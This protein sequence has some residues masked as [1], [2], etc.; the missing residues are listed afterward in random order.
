MRARPNTEPAA[1]LDSPTSILCLQ[2]LP[3][4]LLTPDDDAGPTAGTP[5]RATL[6]IRRSS[7][8]TASPMGLNDHRDALKA[9]GQ[10]VESIK[11]SL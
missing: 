1:G 4:V 8:F 3:R 7:R 11:V 6:E 2:C 5:P 10:R 9:A